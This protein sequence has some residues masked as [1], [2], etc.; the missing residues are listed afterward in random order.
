MADV[1][2]KAKRVLHIKIRA[3]SLDAMTLLASAMKGALPF[4]QA[5]GDAQVH[6]L[7]N[8]DD[9][10]QFLQVIEYQA[11]KE[12][13]LYRHKLASN[14]IVHNYLQAWRSLFPG[15]IEID[16]YEDITENG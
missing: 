11:A 2:E 12:L 8:V 6:L 16:V 7:R 10:T 5:F 1:D 4:L 14:S 13:E 15:A 9:Q 3:P